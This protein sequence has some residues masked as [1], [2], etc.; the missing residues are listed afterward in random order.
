MGLLDPINWTVV[1]LF[2]SF[3][4]FLTAALK[5]QVNFGR[6]TINMGWLGMAIWGGLA[7][8]AQNAGG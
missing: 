7:L 1:W 3:A 4:C 6:L 8:A 5:G 2:V